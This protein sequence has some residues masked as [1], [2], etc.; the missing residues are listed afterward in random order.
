MA[1]CA[2]W[3]AEFVAD[4]W[5]FNL[6]DGRWVD[7]FASSKRIPNRRAYL[8]SRV[9]L[10]AFVVAIF[11]WSVADAALDGAGRCWPIYLTHQGLVIELVYLGAAAAATAKGAYHVD[12]APDAPRGTPA[13]V[14]VAWVLQAIALPGSFL[15]MCLYWLLV[16]DGKLHAV[17]VFTHGVNFLIMAFDQAFSNQPMFLVHGLIF[18]AYAVLYIY[19]TLVHFATRLKD[20]NNNRYIYASLNWHKPDAATRV[21]LGLFL[22][23]IPVVI[24]AF[25][26]ICRNRDKKIAPVFS[27]ETHRPKTDDADAQL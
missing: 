20:C 19:W 6:D 10:F 24:V 4:R 3:K 26:R 11:I 7:L 9:F 8:A 22:V 5:A 17:S 14:K 1:C 12:G 13:V 2:A 23:A 18:V 21:V 16:F 15:I 25:W 27:D